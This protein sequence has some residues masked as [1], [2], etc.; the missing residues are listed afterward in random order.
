MNSNVVFIKMNK[1]NVAYRTNIIFNDTK[2]CLDASYDRNFRKYDP[3]ILSVDFN[4]KDSF[5]N[6]LY[7]H[8]LGPGIDAYKMKFTNDIRYFST[9]IKKGNTIRSL[10]LFTLLRKKVVK[11]S[12]DFKQEL[13][14]VLKTH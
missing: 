3:G 9:Y 8:C 11:K 14:N 5:N 1:K 2:F 10:I 4:I 7:F 12:K 6:S 13:S